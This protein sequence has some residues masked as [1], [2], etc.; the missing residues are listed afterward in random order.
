MDGHLFDPCELT[1]FPT[2]LEYPDVQESKALLLIRRP[3]II[4]S[5]LNFLTIMLVH[6]RASVSVTLS[7]YCTSLFP[8]A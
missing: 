5:A 4:S 3:K 2:F 8:H 6:F 1:L 7:I